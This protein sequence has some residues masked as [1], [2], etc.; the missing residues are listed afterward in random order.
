MWCSVAPWVMPKDA[1]WGARAWRYSLCSLKPAAGGSRAEPAAW[2]GNGG[3]GNC[4]VL[5]WCLALAGGILGRSLAGSPSGCC[6]TLKTPEGP[7]WCGRARPQKVS[8]SGE[9]QPGGAPLWGVGGHPHGVPGPLGHSAPSRFPQLRCT[10]REERRVVPCRQEPTFGVTEPG[11]FPAG[12]GPQGAGADAP[13]KSPVMSPCRAHRYTNAPPPVEERS[14]FAQMLPA[15]WLPFK[16]MVQLMAGWEPGAPP[17][18]AGPPGRTLL[19]P[20]CFGFFSHPQVGVLC[21][22]LVP[23]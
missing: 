6:S 5:S 8:G 14:R 3:V 21:F 10:G 9:G 22:L 17:A 19:F 18:P 12:A 1:P 23:I 20:R 2:T 4:W 15:Q 11:V 13:V 16:E 7:S